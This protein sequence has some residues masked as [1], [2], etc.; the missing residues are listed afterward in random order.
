MAAVSAPAP[1]SLETVRRFVNTRDI[2]AGT[3]AIATATGLET[4]LR[5]A[6]LLAAPDA[7]DDAGVARAVAVREALRAALTAN[8]GGDP[9]PADA[10]ACVNDA[11]ARAGLG[12][13]LTP[14]GGWVAQPTATGVDG[15][16]GALLALVDTAMREATWSR[17]KICVNDACQ[18]AFYD[19]SRARSGKWCSMKICGN[20][21]KQQAWR[22]RTAESAG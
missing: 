4:W 16:L 22:T 10:L 5:E 12:L 21:A 20:R 8:H 13:T 19:H 2:E 1:G 9:V 14:S 6:R 11:A 17:L 3:D 7:V 15:A 18:W